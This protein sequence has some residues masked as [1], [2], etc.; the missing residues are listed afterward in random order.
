MGGRELQVCI[1]ESPT[2]VDITFRGSSPC[3]HLMFTGCCTGDRGTG[4]PR[5]LMS[6]R[7]E[8]LTIRRKW[9]M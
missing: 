6:P 4:S 8:L 1:K 7:K 9:E 3:E 5:H 2:L